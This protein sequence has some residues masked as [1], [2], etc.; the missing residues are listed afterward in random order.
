VRKVIENTPE[1]TPSFIETLIGLLDDYI[2]KAEDALKVTEE[3]ETPTK[4]NDDLPF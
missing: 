2:P 4:E 1:Y 3:Q